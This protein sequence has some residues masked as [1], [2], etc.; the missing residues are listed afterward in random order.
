MPATWLSRRSWHCSSAKWT[1]TR[2]DQ[3]RIVLAALERAQKFRRKTRAAGE[4]GDPFAAAHRSDR[5]DSG[6][7]RDPDAGQLAAFPEIVEIAIIEKELGDD[8][9]GAG[10]DF[11]FEV[12]H[13]DE[14]I[15][16]R[17]M[18]LRETGHADPEPARIGMR[19][20]FVKLADE[21]SRRSAAFWNAS[22]DLS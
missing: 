5:H 12:I 16:R 7:D 3:F 18:A 20:A 21:S 14:P 8:I 19:A 4:L 11:R 22:F 2:V 9:I 13:L 6:D 1:P 17:R 15:R 10:I